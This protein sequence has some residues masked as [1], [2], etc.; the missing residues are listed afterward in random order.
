MVKLNSEHINA[1]VSE[2]RNKLNDD[3]KIKKAEADLNK[4]YKKELDSLTKLK[5]ESEEVYRKADKINRAYNAKI[6]EVNIELKKLCNV[7]FN[8]S[9]LS[10]KDK[11]YI[12]HPDFIRHTIKI[13]NDLEIRNAIVLSTLD[14]KSVEEIISKLVQ[15]FK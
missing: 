6:S 14:S 5:K 3:I 10:T 1:L 2:V 13:P 11:S 8:R 4:K 15:K 9:V 7:Y 12:L